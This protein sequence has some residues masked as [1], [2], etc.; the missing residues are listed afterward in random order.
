MNTLFH[1]EDGIFIIRPS[2]KGFQ[3][4]HNGASGA[5]IIAGKFHTLGRAQVLVG[6]PVVQV[7]GFS[8]FPVLRLGSQT[9][10]DPI[11]AAVALA[12]SVS[13]GRN[14]LLPREGAVK[15]NMQ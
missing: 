10:N 3:L 9:T 12:V 6:I 8:A 1:F 7:K 2:C 14:F 11:V 5:T 13:K 4:S 15:H